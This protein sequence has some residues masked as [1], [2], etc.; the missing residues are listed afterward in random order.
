MTYFRCVFERIP[1]S[2]SEKT[3]GFCRFQ[4]I[5]GQ[6]ICRGSRVGI[7]NHYIQ[8]PV[9]LFIMCYN[10]LASMVKLVNTRDLKFLAERFAGSTPATRTKKGYYELRR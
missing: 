1:H 2:S 3:F 8:L 5:R 9:F 10:G 7:V 4:K 6:E